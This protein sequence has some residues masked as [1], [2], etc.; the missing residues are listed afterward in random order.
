M[1]CQ[2]A[3]ARDARGG[4]WVYVCGFRGEFMEEDAPCPCEHFEARV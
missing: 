2:H 3:E 1:N 4:I